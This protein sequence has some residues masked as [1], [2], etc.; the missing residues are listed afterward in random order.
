MVCQS[1]VVDLNA[2]CPL[3]YAICQVNYY[4][5]MNGATPGGADGA[6][7]ASLQAVAKYKRDQA[8]KLARTQRDAAVDG[9]TAG[10]RERVA[11]MEKLI[12][13]EAVRRYDA[14]AGTTT[15]N[16]L[17]PSNGDP[18]ERAL[19]TMFDES[20]LQQDFRERQEQALTKNM[21]TMYARASRF[22][23]ARMERFPNIGV[24]VNK[25]RR[26]TAAAVSRTMAEA[27][28]GA[29][30]RVRQ[31]CAATCR[32]GF[33]LYVA[34]SRYQQSCGVVFFMYQPP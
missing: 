1:N 34:W 16:I 13:A 28:A 32:H 3:V 30:T 14:K 12:S 9:A 11:M 6:T 21:N 27:V 23:D 5:T 31:C 15:S 7:L 8:D 2:K 4:A 33:P 10:A 24:W 19:E 29:R 20:T 25:Q 26:N 17:Y 18:K 22:V